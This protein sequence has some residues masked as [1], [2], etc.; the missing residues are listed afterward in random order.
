MQYESLELAAENLMWRE[1]D[2]IRNSVTMAASTYYS[3]KELQGKGH[4]TKL[5]MLREK[6]IEW[7]DYPTHF[8]QGIFAR[9]VTSMVKLSD[10]ELANIP[11]KFRPDP[12]NMTVRTRVENVELAAEKLEA[13]TE[14]Q[15]VKFLFI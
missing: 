6:D 13:V 15:R 1:T 4:N 2:A 12:N 14:E 11:E 9:R 8:K 5:K 7:N 3:H 10:A